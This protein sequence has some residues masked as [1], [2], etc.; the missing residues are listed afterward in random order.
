VGS[1]HLAA[2]AVLSEWK[3]RREERKGS[4]ARGGVSSVRCDYPG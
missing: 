2:L 1:L 4:G 3:T